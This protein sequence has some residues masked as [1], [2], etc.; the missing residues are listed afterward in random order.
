MARASLLVLCA[1]AS[2]ALTA[3]LLG[4]A[5]PYP[6][7]GTVDDKLRF[8]ED[9]RD[10][11]DLLV[12]GS[13]RV[14]RGIVP[15]E[16]DTEMARRGVPVRSFNFGAD[17]MDSHETAAL[18]RRVLEMRP[19]RVRWVVVELDRWS[20]ELP[21]EN[22][23]KRRTVFWHDREET[24]SVLRTL[25]R[26]EPSRRR[27]LDLT[28]AHLLHLAARSTAAGRGRSLMGAAR[29]RLGSGREAVREAE[30]ELAR[31]GGFEPFSPGAYEIPSH[32]PF[33]RRFLERLP[34]Y[35]RAVARL[36]AANRAVTALDG[37]NVEAVARQVA[38]IRRAGA[39]PVHLITPTARPTPEL[40]RLAE[41]GHVP[42]LVAF[43]DPMAYPALF[44]EERRFDAEHLTTEGARR[45]SRLLAERLAGSAE[46]PDLGEVRVA[47][48]GLKER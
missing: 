27:R 22:R 38:A 29:D 11:Y 28:A 8:F 13:S 3:A 17:G 31:S 41:A 19:R 14:F 23:F 43:N 40:Y 18:V 48:A 26:T 32:H 33:R 5:A 21:P 34:A 4:R 1:A 12:F 35:R 10:D 30:A 16:I 45:F 6:E 25:A 37:Y 2:F 36:P 39:R 44:A 20:A 24:L 42:H 7:M 47:R 15:E 9:R 46:A